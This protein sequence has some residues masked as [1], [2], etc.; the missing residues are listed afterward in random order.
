MGRAELVGGSIRA[1]ERDWDIELTTR[2]R[3]HIWGVVHN[4]IKGDERKTERHEL[5]DRPQ[6]DHRRSDAEAGKSIFTNRSI[7]NPAR[8]KTLKQTVAYFVSALIF[9]NLFAH[10][11]NVRITLKLLRERFVECLTISN[12]P[13][14][15]FSVAAAVSAAGPLDFAGGTPAS[16]APSA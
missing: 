14:P 15:L 5:N 10:E 6:A 9:G 12:F 13:H 3:E 4:L 7:D 1:A 8:S 16:T 11:K 2:H